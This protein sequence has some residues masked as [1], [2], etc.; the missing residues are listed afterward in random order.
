M[1]RVLLTISIAF[2]C[3]GELEVNGDLKVS[4]N[5][6][7]GTIDSLQQV[8][9]T[10]QLQ[11]EESNS[12]INNLV[13]PQAFNGL[14]TYGGGQPTFQVPEGITRIAVENSKLLFL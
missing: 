3:A 8:I 1:R 11:I 12:L 2:L 14:H 4:G 5:I 13:I 7:A 10:L 9:G 6:E